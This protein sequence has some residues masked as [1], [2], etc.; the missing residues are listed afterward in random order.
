MVNKLSQIESLKEGLMKEIKTKT[1][2]VML[3]FQV[4]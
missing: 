4:R 3:K 2:E 1:T